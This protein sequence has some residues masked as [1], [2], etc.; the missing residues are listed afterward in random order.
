VQITVITR[1]TEFHDVDIPVPALADLLPEQMWLRGPSEA[2]PGQLELTLNLT[3]DQLI[4]AGKY[5]YAANIF[6]EI[7]PEEVEDVKTEADAIHELENYTLDMLDLPTEEGEWEFLYFTN[8][9]STPTELKEWKDKIG[10]AVY[11]PHY[12]GTADA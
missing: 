7:Q 6:F 4:Q 12:H 9:I 11:G 8:R 1:L 2:F 3:A 10:T 5:F